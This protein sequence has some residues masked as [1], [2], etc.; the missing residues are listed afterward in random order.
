MRP[1]QTIAAAVVAALMLAA[2]EEQAPVPKA[3]EFVGVYS[4][5]AGEAQATIA[6]AAETFEAAAY[7]PAVA[8]G[9]ARAAATAAD[10]AGATWRQLA[11]TTTAVA[12][13]V[14]LKVATVRHDGRGLGGAALA[15]YTACRITAPVG[16]SLADR[17]LA[18]LMQCLGVT[19]AV[20][21]ERGVRPSII[22]SWE[23]VAFRPDDG[24]PEWR[25]GHP[26]W[27]PLWLEFSATEL[28]ASGKCPR[29]Q[30]QPPPQ[31]CTRDSYVTRFPLT[32]E[33]TAIVLHLKNPE[34][35]QITPVRLSYVLTDDGQRLTLKYLA[36]T[37]TILLERE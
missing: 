30:G 27:S 9:S 36:P 14:T 22:G 11:G 13:T 3:A 33:E 1:R 31:P 32:I 26:R 10:D 35:A 34:T 2:C 5:T 4:G 8:R 18:A 37:G 16:A 19:E 29:V 20:E 6:V 28:R 17:L 25:E 24:T 7:T 15:R 23:A 12:G 21:V